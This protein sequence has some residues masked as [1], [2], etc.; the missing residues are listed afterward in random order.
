MVH[1]NCGRIAFPGPLPQIVL[2]RDVSGKD[3]CFGILYSGSL[4]RL[5]A[6]WEVGRLLLKRSLGTKE[7]Q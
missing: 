4:Y 6:A 1:D 5:M 7:L 2:D 3:D